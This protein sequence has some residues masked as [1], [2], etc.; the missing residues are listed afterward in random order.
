MPEIT[1]HE[2]PTTCS[3]QDQ[4][5]TLKVYTFNDDRWCNKL[6]NDI[7]SGISTIEKISQGKET[8]LMEVAI[9][10]SHT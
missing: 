10:G 7:S 4:V 5:P 9:F 6:V 3:E 8:E 1:W 2:G